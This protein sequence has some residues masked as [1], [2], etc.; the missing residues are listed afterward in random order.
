[1]ID[2]ITFDLWNTLTSNT[3]EDAERF[4]KLRTMGIIKAFLTKG[5]KFEKE[6]VGK[7]LDLTFEKC[8][9]LWNKNI[10]FSAEE[11]LEIL[12]KFLPDLGQ[13]LTPD[14]LKKVEEA[15]TESVLEIPS[16]LVEGSLE[17]LKY[18]NNEK[19]KLGLICNT[20]RSP[21]RV[22]RKL[23]EYYH[24]SEYF[25]VMTFSDELRIR[26]PD[27]EIFLFTLK[28]LK[29]TPSSSIHVGDELE[30]DIKGAK[31][32]GMTAIHLNRINNP[33]KEIQPDYSIRKLKEIKKVVEEL[34]RT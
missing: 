16:E 13:N 10:D 22:L 32:V 31:S 30:T 8:W 33:H 11:Q 29:S 24:I 6:E 5:I 9:D 23:L 4:K 15:Y 2:T 17:I 19:Y 25:N 26:K 14:L 28:K 3:P 27:P 18:L 21:G 34:K 7:A 20:G 12:F 1:L